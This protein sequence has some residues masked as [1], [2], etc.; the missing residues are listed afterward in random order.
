M[1]EVPR[2]SRVARWVKSGSVLCSMGEEVGFGYH[3]RFGW[4]FRFNDA[5]AVVER[6]H[7]EG[8]K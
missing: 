2:V 8:R 5:T 4:S 7:V 6:E 1:V 3:L